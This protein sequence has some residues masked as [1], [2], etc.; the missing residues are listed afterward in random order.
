MTQRKPNFF[1]VGAPKC[2]TT[3][4][5]T[6]LKTHPDVFMSPM[7]EPH[8]FATDFDMPR[9][10]RYQ[11]EEAYMDLFQLAGDKKRVGEASVWYLY[12]RKAAQNIAEFA[13]DAKIIIMLRNPVDMLYS[14]HGQLLYGNVENLESFEE[15]LHAE[16]DRKAGHR[17]PDTNTIM[18]EALYYS[19][20]V[21]FAEQVQRFYDAFGED[22][23]KVILFDDFKRDVETVFRETLEFLEIDPAFQTDLGVVNSHRVVRNR[24]IQKTVHRLLE[25]DWYRMQFLPRVR[26]FFPA[27]VRRSVNNAIISTHS[28]IRKRDPLDAEIKQRLQKRFQPEVDAL[29]ELLN[30][31]L[32]HWY[33]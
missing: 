19:E 16:E 15:A 22:Q 14:L 32:S 1:I 28:D 27:S 8:Y 4:L 17:I 20:I 30:R 23:V 25:M 9:L 5:Y 6:Y 10:A 3:A 31:D 21:R 12:S 29:G 24:R 26:K 33:A 2:G 11:T 13:P 18:P 7:K